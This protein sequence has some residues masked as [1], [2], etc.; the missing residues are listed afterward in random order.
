MQ[1]ALESARLQLEGAATFL[2]LD[3]GLHQLL[4]TQWHGDLHGAPG[5]R[6]QLVQPVV[7][8]EEGG[9]AL[10]LEEGG[11]ERRLHGDLLVGRR[12]R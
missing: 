5:R 12:H 10:E 11:L 6:E 3:D 9:R 8:A 4:A 1:S 7:E 2:G